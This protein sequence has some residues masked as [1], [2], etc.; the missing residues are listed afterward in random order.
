M[1]LFDLESDKIRNFKAAKKNTVCKEDDA[2]QF[3]PSKEMNPEPELLFQTVK[4]LPY[5]LP[6]L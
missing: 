2:S 3:D 6:Y 1:T 5:K 4:N